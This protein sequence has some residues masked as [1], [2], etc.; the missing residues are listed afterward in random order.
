MWPAPEQIAQDEQGPAVADEVERHGYRAE[1]VD[2]NPGL[3][4]TVLADRLRD[5]TE[6]G[7][8]A[9]F[10]VRD[11]RRAAVYRLTDAGRQIEPVIAALY[12]FGGVTLAT[13]RLTPAKVGY[14]LDL[15][16]RVVGDAVYDLP[17]ALVRLVIDDLEVDVALAPGS[18]RVEEG[19]A[20]PNAK[21][22]LDKATFL[23]LVA[24]E[25]ATP[26]VVEG[27]GARAAALL[28]LLAHASG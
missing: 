5:L 22:H 2:A 8:V 19:A 9:R 25:E 10:E 15:A 4:P 12:D 20:R 28:E 17:E 16:T 21:V 26:T 13:T 7:L 3:S 23:T 27:D 18:A 6:E 24:G 11:G 14:V 1:L